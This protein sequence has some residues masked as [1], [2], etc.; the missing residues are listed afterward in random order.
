MSGLLSGCHAIVFDGS[1]VSNVDGFAALPSG[2]GD[3]LDVSVPFGDEIV[4]YSIGPGVVC[5]SGASGDARRALRRDWAGCPGDGSSSPRS[6]SPATVSRSRRCTGARSRCSRDVLTLGRGG[7]IFAPEGQLLEA[8]ELLVQPGLVTALEM[9][10]DEGAAERLSRFALGDAARRWTAWSSPPPTLPGYA[11]R[12]T[13]PVLTGLP[14]AARRHARR[15]LRCARSPTPP[16]PARRSL[17]DRPC[18][19]AG[20]GARGGRDGRRAH[21]QH[22]RRRRPGRRLR[23]HPLARRRRRSLGARVSTCS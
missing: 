3:L 4:V 14:R 21:H 13:D 1:R 16:S 17:R 15:A 20:R 11:P 8:G 22:G 23:P 9:L 2:D 5:G 12:W 19:R 18:A 10:A 7:E 6:T